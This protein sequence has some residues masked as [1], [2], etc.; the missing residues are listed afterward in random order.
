VPYHL[1]EGKRR[2]E[3]CIRAFMDIDEKIPHIE[4]QLKYLEHW[5]QL[6]ISHHGC[7]DALR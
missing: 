7:F 1:L 6:C 3:S 5:A 4:P 2:A